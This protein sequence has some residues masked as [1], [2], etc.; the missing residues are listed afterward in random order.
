MDT[1]EFGRT[2]LFTSVLTFGPMRLDPQRIEAGEALRL[3]EHLHAGGVT[4]FHSSSEYETHGFFCE[5]MRRFRE[6]HP[7]TEQVHVCKLA[8]PHFGED[9]FQ[10]ERFRALVE[11]A[12]RDLGADHLHLVQWLLRSKPIADEPR[13]RLLAESAAA[14]GRVWED[15]RAEGK[16]GVLAS[17]PYSVPF[18]GAVL[19]TPPCAGLVTYLNLAELDEAPRLDAMERAGQGFVAI[20]PLHAGAL[21]LDAE[22]TAFALRFPLLHPAVSSVVVGVS[23][24][25]HADAALAALQHVAPDRSRFDEIVAARRSLPG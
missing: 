6:R 17:F 9:R 5:V 18:A 11:Q 21:A 19:E 2:G 20:R 16:V 14:L 25:P 3:I 1:R 4:T 8:A 7:G 13:L 24:I 15:L 12:L 10:P 22:R 23:S